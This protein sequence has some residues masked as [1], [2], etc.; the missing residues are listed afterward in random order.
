VVGGHADQQVAEPAGGHPRHGPAEALA[1]PAAA[2]G[3]PAKLA[4]VG[5]VEVLHQDRPAESFRCDAKNR[6]DGRTQP[7]VAG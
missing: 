6:A 7:S 4:G 1:P 5:E 2:E 3:L